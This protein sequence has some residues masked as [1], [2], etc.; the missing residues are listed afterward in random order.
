VLIIT[1]FHSKV[2]FSGKKRGAPHY[3]KNPRPEALED[4]ATDFLF[5]L[6]EKAF[7]HIMILAQKKSLF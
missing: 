1:V 5:S 4:K 6:S 7:Q 3:R 2:K